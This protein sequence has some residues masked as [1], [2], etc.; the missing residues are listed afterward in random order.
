MFSFFFRLVT[1]CQ[2][3]PE[4]RGEGKFTFTI[5]RQWCSSASAK[6][7]LSR[8]QS[9]ACLS[10]AEAATRMSVV[11]DDGRFIFPKECDSVACSWAKPKNA[12]HLH[13]GREMVSRRGLTS[14]SSSRL[15]I[16]QTSLALLSLAASV[17]PL[18]ALSLLLI[19]FTFIAL[20]ILASV[21]YFNVM[22]FQV[23][24]AH[25]LL[26]RSGARPSTFP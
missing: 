14:F 24:P 1:A 8:T 7:R 11:C 10:Y 6:E 20:A 9:Q 26:A 12:L 18:P 3:T 19:G 16:A 5:P 17:H 13:Q 25:V 15:G 23:Y 4:P 2:R 21:G 22:L